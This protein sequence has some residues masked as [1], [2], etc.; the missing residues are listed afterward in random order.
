MPREKPSFSQNP[1]QNPEQA[2]RRESDDT[3]HIL[4]V[5]GGNDSYPWL[6]RCIS[7]IERLSEFPYRVHVFTYNNKPCPSWVTRYGVT[8]EFNSFCGR[9]FRG[10]TDYTSYPHQAALSYLASKLI[11]SWI[12]TIDSDSIPI[13]QGWNQDLREQAEPNGVV[14]V[15]RRLG[16]DVHP[17]AENIAHPSCLCMS[18]SR[19]RALKRNFFGWPRSG[20]NDSTPPGEYNDTAARLTRMIR[21][22]HVPLELMKRDNDFAGLEALPGSGPAL[23][24]TYADLVYHHGCGSRSFNRRWPSWVREL[25]D[26]ILGLLDTDFEEFVEFIKKGKIGS[27]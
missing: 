6:D 14:A 16:K 4:I 17:G 19:Y 10:R 15:S 7:A 23:F 22:N 13:K 12:I 27:R 1:W 25:S 8:G 9:T 24:G 2:R 3:T 26:K 18:V 21:K 5:E 20:Y 11:Q